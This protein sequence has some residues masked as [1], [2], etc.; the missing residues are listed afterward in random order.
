V[1][2]RTYPADVSA[3]EHRNPSEIDSRRGWFDE[4]A[5]HTQDIVSR[6]VFF[7]ALVVLTVLW[8]PSYWIFGEI[9]HWYLSFVIPAEVITLFMVALLANHDR[10]TDQA[11]QRKVDA[12]AAALAAMAESSADP[13]VHDHARELRAALG[14]EDRES[15]EEA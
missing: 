5:A 14:L 15:T 1:V 2:D 12:L 13:K 7:I 6:D 3:S 11:L 10:R 9:N 4:L 8:I